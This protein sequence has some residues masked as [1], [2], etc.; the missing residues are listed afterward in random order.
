M[1][2]P[3]PDTM[4]ARLLVLLFGFTWHELA[5]ATAAWLLGDP[6][7]KEEGCLTLNPA[8]HIDPI[9]ALMLLVTGFGWSQTTC[10]NPARMTRVRSPRV[11]MAIVAAAGPLANLLLAFLGMLVFYF[12]APITDHLI[13]WGLSPASV[14]KGWALFGMVVFIEIL[15]AFFNF[16]PIPPLDGATILEGIAAPPIANFIAWMRGYGCLFFLLFFFV[17]PKL[18]ID[19]FSPLIFDATL[20]FLALVEMLLGW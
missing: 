1:S 11:A 16:I 14:E 12:E 15:L 20:R 7:P 5:H 13:A 8:R 9:G 6:T 19:L 2:L 4:L 10:L 17:L 18:G 3:S